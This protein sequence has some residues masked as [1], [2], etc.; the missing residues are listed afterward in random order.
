[1]PY[2]PLKIWR[3]A[4]HRRSVSRE[5]IPGIEGDNSCRAPKALRAEKC[6]A[7]IEAAAH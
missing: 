2:V 4:I 6:V 7:S 5:L 3:T 1:M